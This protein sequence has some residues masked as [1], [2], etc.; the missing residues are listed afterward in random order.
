MKILRLSLFNL[1]KNRREAL[2]I[3]FLTMI[4]T[5]MVSI[6]IT[7]IGKIDTVFE[8]CFEATGS[9]H[10][11]VMFR[12]DLYRDEYREILEKEYGPERLSEND[13]IF[14][15]STD[16]R[17]ADG[18]LIS[19]NFLFVTEKTERKLESFIKTEQLPE[20]E[21][22]KK[23]YPIWL[24]EVFSIVKHYRPG[25]CISILAMGREYPFE[26]AG[27]YKTGLG[28]SDQNVHKCVISEEGFELLSM[29]FHDSYA[30]TF[31]A[32]CFDE[33][34]DFSYPEFV[35]KCEEASGENIRVGVFKNSFEGEKYQETMFLNIFLYIIA[36]LAAVTMVA[37]LFMV[38][39]KISN[40]IE[41]QMQQIGVLEALGYRSS[42]ISGAYLCEY[43]ISGGVGAVL[44][45]ILSV[46]MIPLMDLAVRM[47]MG[48]EIAGNTR[49]GGIVAVTL[50]MILLVTLFALLKAGTV[51]RYPPVVALRKGI[52]THHF[53]KSIL[54]LEKT[55][56]NINARL[57]LKAFLSDIRSGIGVA[58]CIIL[59]GTALLFSV[60]TFDVFREG[61]KGME[62]MQNYD[63]DTVWVM[64][65]PGIDIYGLREEIESMSEVRK[66]LVSYNIQYLSVKGS[67]DKAMIAV[68]DDYGDS[69][70]IRPY[71]G[72][73]PERDNEVCIGLSRS[74]RESYGIGDSIVL[75][76]GG[77]EKSYIITGI[78]GSMMNGGT[79]V[80]LTSE[81]YERV[82]NNARPD[83]IVIYPKEGVT[84]EVLEAALTERFGEKA[85]NYDTEGAGAGSTEERIRAAAE[86][87]I[88]ALMAQYGVTSVDYAIRIGDEL[89][90]GNSRQFM[91]KQIKSWRGNIKAQLAP[92]A[93]VTKSFTLIAMVFIAAI[94]AVI[95][96]IIASSAV[97]RQRRSLGIMKSMGYSSKDLMTQMALKIIPVTLISMV[98]ASGIIIYVNK[99]FWELAFGVVIK[100]NIPLIVVTDILMTLFCYA[101]TYIGAGRIKKISVT[102]LMT[103]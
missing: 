10:Q 1:K 93:E 81:G 52:E 35:D 44:G 77:M 66:A 30:N 47:M 16:V 97:R 21:L 17:E 62:A 88:A 49:I 43:V 53:G 46:L 36:G 60:L 2:A 4:T 101:V 57:A 19:Y 9:V 80:Y 102:E 63:I 92:I 91:I 26:V 45:G 89:I 70:N 12:K 58:V 98:L 59:S 7:N 54:P 42:E 14:S 67:E 72:R 13:I 83:C 24:P 22:A 51:K 84:D 5:I 76:F 68:F 39:N 95:L 40:D 94:V 32:L 33:G 86:E 99:L 85:D 25:D 90:T 74:K 38:R 3:A 48:R 96:T 55:R 20:E 29:I 100:T 78:L 75:G 6:F 56:G 82:N 61:T 37:S 64:T 34:G 87:K 18:N 41:D 65:M 79:G 11:M 71:I 23:A 31:R 69:E 27:F 50:A 103:E 73:L 8:E 28:A 15:V